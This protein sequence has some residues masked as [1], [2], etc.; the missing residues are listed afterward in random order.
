MAKIWNCVRKVLGSDT[1]GD[2][3]F[4]A[5]VSLSRQ[6]PGFFSIMPRSRP[7]KTFFSS[8]HTAHPVI[9]AVQLLVTTAS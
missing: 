7:F 6:I 3:F 1:S 8:L 5:S 2:R 4:M 9:G